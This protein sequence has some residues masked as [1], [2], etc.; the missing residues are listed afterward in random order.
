MHY[1]SAHSSA[2]ALNVNSGRGVQENYDQSGGSNDRQ[3]NA[4]II[5]YHHPSGKHA[6]RDV[7]GQAREY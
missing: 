6:N 1:P 5:N 2:G 7:V 3:F 4:E